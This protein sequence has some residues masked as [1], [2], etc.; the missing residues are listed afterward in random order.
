MR[1]R[2]HI[3]DPMLVEPETGARD[4][5]YP[6]QDNAFTIISQPRCN[7]CCVIVPLYPFD[8]LIYP[9]VLVSPSFYDTLKFILIVIVNYQIVTNQGPGCSNFVYLPDKNFNSMSRD[10]DYTIT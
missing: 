2:S 4:T 6:S 9:G 10:Q 8:I 3:S 7:I 5:L 1:M